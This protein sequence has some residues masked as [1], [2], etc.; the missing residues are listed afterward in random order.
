MKSTRVALVTGAGSGLGAAV[1]HALAEAGWTVA[2]LDVTRAD[3]RTELAFAADVRDAPAVDEAVSETASRFG[4]L[5]GVACCAGV[6]RNTLTPLHLLSDDAW[7]T[8]LDV[9]LNGAFHTARAALP[10]LMNHRGAIVFVASVASRFPQPGGSAYA[11]SKG[12]IAS[13]A[14]AI[15][16]EYGPRGVRANSVSPGYMD[17]P[18]AA[19]LLSRQHLRERVEHGLP[20]RRVAEPGEVAAAIGF[21]LSPAAAQ[22]SGEDLDV[23]GAG[24][25]TGY[26]TGADLDRMWRRATP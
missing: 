11:A 19:P 6:F 4:R 9:N 7:T 23:D 15:A 8:T 22:V 10:H 18:M 24:A 26:T 5:D 2:G 1:S 3:C 12:G 16:L 13:L 25:L 21:L 14:R 17:T 20:A